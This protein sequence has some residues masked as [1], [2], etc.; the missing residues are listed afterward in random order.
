MFGLFKNE[1]IKTCDL[2]GKCIHSQIIKVL[3]E[4]ETIFTKGDN[5]KELIFFHTYLSGLLFAAAHYKNI[6]VD[7]TLD[8]KYKKYIIDGINPD[9]WPY[10]LKAED[11]ISLE[12]S[13]TFD[14]ESLQEEAKNAGHYDATMTNIADVLNLYRFLTGK[15]LLKY[16]E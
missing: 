14:V 7:F 12:I 13:P 2:V 9:F 16:N 6:N 11:L 1:K 10:F 8:N 4:K 5:S 15:E 3:E